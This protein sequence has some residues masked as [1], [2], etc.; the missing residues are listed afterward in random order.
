MTDAVNSAPPPT[1]LVIDTSTAQG[2]VA[3][4]DGQRISSRS[5]PAERNHTTT[6]LAQIHR[7]L[8]DAG[9]T[10]D[11]LA[12]IG[13]ATGPGAFTALRVGMGLAKGFH[14]A[15]NTPLVGVSTLLATALPFSGLGHPII[16]T[17]PAGRGRLV[18]ARYEGTSPAMP[19]LDAPRNGDLP[20]LLA[21]LAGEPG[22][23]VI[24][25]GELESGQAEALA[26]LP[27]VLVPP[28]ALRQRQPGA[29]AELTWRAWRA[30]DVADPAALEPVY[31]SR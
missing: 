7:L 8:D 4:Y 18:W 14:L 29:F 24:I 6:S 31:L 19:E 12:A 3:L 16:A 30:G 1:I 26:A 11:T 22:T 23:P 20:T 28:L 10:S 2:A 9:I 15:A 25:A 21:E 5:W 13:V 17:L 27:H